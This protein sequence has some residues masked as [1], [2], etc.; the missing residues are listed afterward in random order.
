MKKAIPG[1]LVLL[2]AAVWLWLTT[3]QGPQPAPPAVRTAEQA[4]A[5]PPSPA[6]LAAWDKIQPHLAAAEKAGN[7][8]VE[9]HCDRVKEFFAERR[10]RARPFAEQALSL[11]SKWAFVK[12]KL[13]LTDGDGHREYLREQFEEIVFSGAELEEVLQSAV[14]GCVAELQGIENELLVKVRADLS[15]D[16]VGAPSSDVRFPTEAALHEQYARAVEKAAKTFRNDLP[17]WGGREAV[18]WVGADLTAPIIQ[19]LAASLIARLGLSGGIMGGSVASGAITLGG[20]VIAGFVID[21]LLDRL[22]RLLGYDP[23]SDIEEQ[24]IQSLR[25]SENLILQ[26]EGAAD[27]ARAGGVDKKDAGK[28]L[29]YYLSALSRER[30]KLRNEALRKLVLEGGER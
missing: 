7:D 23:E 19:S 11:G 13:P 5:T 17:V 15:D 4:P 26:G 2:G 14:K 1:V 20:G 12:S 25:D 29:H 22:L 6:A 24:V 21:A 28:G 16:A 3:Q 30:T 18:T 27:A 9:K 10:K 8:V